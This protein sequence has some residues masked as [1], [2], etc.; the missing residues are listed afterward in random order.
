MADS[1]GENKIMK[2]HYRTSGSTRHRQNLIRQSSRYLQHM[3]KSM[4]QMNLKLHKVI[5]DLAGKTGMS[6]VKAILKASTIRT[7]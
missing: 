2:I 4:E 1:I 7:S 5:R 6:I 3:Q